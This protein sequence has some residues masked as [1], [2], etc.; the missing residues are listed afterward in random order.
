MGRKAKS[1]AVATNGVKDNDVKVTNKGDNGVKKES[2]HKVQE[3]RVG[4]PKSKKESV[5]NRAA[6]AAFAS[7]D[8]ASEEVKRKRVRDEKTLYIRFKVAADQLP[9]TPADV[10]GLHPAISD[11]RITRQNTSEGFKYCHVQ[12]K[13]PED[14]LKAK[15][16]LGLKEFRGGQ[17]VVDGVGDF[18]EAATK[19]GRKNRGL[20]NNA[21]H[22]C[23]LAVLGVPSN[24]KN[25]AL[26]DLFPGCTKVTIPKGK[27]RTLKSLAFIEFSN[28]GTAKT[29]FDKSTNLTLEGNKLHVTFAKKTHMPSGDSDVTDK[30]RSASEEDD[31]E[32]AVASKKKKKTAAAA[33]VEEVKEESAEEEDGDEEEASAEEEDMEAEEES[34]DDAAEIDLEATADKDEEGEEDDSDN[35]YEDDDDS[36]EE[37]E[38][39]PLQKKVKD[40]REIITA[41]KATKVDAEDD[42]DEDEEESDE[43]GNEEEGEEESDDGEEGEGEEGEEEEGEEEE[44]EGEESSDDE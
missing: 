10:W 6:R 14:T 9:K 24:A 37:K 27:K 2:I 44:V 42:D 5:L 30:K 31:K 13:T 12:F 25:G 26:R 28:P 21:V 43:D 7:G 22:P 15:T 39:S 8:V 36:E 23:R 38:A 16:A 29:A 34:D 40:L 41:K 19:E 20:G 35:D 1:K 33:K 17:L 32:N 4:R 11:V 3:G 18:S